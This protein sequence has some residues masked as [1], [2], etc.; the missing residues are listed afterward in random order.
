MT[1]FHSVGTVSVCVLLVMAVA[2]QTPWM[3]HER[4]ETGTSSVTGYVIEDEPG[5]VK[6]LTEDRELTLIDTADVTGREL[7]D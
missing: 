5:F 1:L 2:V 6:L 3:S 7:L 4:V